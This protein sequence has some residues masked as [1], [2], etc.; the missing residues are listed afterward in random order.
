MR[1]KDGR[2]NR[3]QYRWLVGSGNGPGTVC[4]G[5][6]AVKNE[7]GGHYCTWR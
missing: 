4:D 2:L 7:D 6:A 1:F 3:G 5:L